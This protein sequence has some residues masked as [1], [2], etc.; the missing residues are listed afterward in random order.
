MRADISIARTRERKLVNTVSECE[1]DDVPRLK[2]GI[3]NLDRLLGGDEDPGI[4][5]GVVIQ[6]AGNPGIGKSTLLAQIAG[7][8]LFS[9]VLYI[10]SEEKIS[11]IGRRAKRLRMKHANDIQVIATRSLGT[12]KRAIEECGAK[13]VIADSLQGL[14]LKDEDEE[15]GNGELRMAKH[16]QQTV[17]DIAVSLISVSH[18]QGCT[19]V[20]VGHMNKQET[21]AGL[22]EIEHLVDIVCFFKG[23]PNKPE[24]FVECSK[25][26]E[27]DTFYQAWFKMTQYGLME[28]TA[29]KQARKQAPEHVT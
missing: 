2:T 16:T 10:T 8:P 14:R 24:R 19:I 26:R 15:D 12:A 4:P 27:G 3:G 29:P 28:S 21:M 11:R 18:K 23:N 17:R 1:E 6:L 13:I 22:K 7:G 20:L 5:H 25:N 9:D